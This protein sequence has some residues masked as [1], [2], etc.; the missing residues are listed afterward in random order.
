VKKNPI[1]EQ[2]LKA[3]G[4]IFCM[5]LLLNCGPNFERASDAQLTQLDDFDSINEFEAFNKTS[6]GPDEQDLKNYE[7]SRAYGYLWG[8][9]GVATDGSVYLRKTNFS[10]GKHFKSV[11]DS[12]F[13]DDLRE[14]SQGSRY[15]V[16]I[17]GM[18]AEKFLDQG[19]ANW[20]IQDRRAFLASVIETEGAS[21]VGRIADDP[22]LSRCEFIRDVVNDLNS[23]CR[24]NTCTGPSCK[25]P[26]CA[27]IAKG[28]S[29]G[30]PHRAG[31]FCG[32]YLSGDSDDWTSMFDTDQ[33][34]FV[35]TDR[36]PGEEPT[37]RGT[38]SRPFY[39]NSSDVPDEPDSG[40]EGSLEDYEYSRSL[41]YLWGDG[42]LADNG[43]LFFRKHTSGVSRHFASTAESYF[44]DLLK[45]ISGKYNIKL[46]G[47]NSKDFLDNGPQPST[48]KDKRA[49]LTS[50]IETE[51]AVLVGRIADDP[52]LSRC[53]YIRDVVNDIN[54]SC[55]N[56]T[57]S[58]PNCNV[59]NCAFIAHGSS[60]GTPHR[61]GRNCGVYLSGKFDDWGD[62]LQTNEFWFV[63]TGRVP[64][65]EP[66]QRN[67]SSRPS[68]TE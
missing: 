49:F 38:E 25:V 30:T 43:G 54:P 28:N 58:G 2:T 55:T 27:F 42:G 21:G 63:Q 5:L 24:T 51:G 15:L 22:K 62:M 64:G 11:G 40:S 7:R 19:P 3:A 14:N 46:P 20:M 68:Y 10:V 33:Y 36:T 47:I 12:F 37:E 16:K 17:P 48:I 45:V 8:D 61:V 1:I 18:T 9:G 44:G 57:C 50:V 29:R 59:P 65:G 41:G 31:Q 52:K 4:A 66:T 60:R 26:N 56:S 34:W 6:Y 23:E 67:A 39:T 35:K 13:G 53:E 32:V